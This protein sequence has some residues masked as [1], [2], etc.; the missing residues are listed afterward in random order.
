MATGN[1]AT[2]HATTFS[3]GT[4]ALKCTDIS[5]EESYP[6]PKNAAASKL[7]A[8]TL[9][10]AVGAEKVQVAEPL[11]DVSDDDDSK[12]TT[13]NVTFLVGPSGA[14]PATGTEASITTTGV[15]AGTFRCTKCQQTR[16]VN[17]LVECQAT[18][19]SVPATATVTP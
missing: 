3:F 15:S 14:L 8:S 7:D 16:K 5:I 4:L 13:V 18:F 11:K 12:T 2:S 17:A 19:V 9:D 1:F 10:L 6:E